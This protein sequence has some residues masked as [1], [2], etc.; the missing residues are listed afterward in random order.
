MVV[1]ECKPI[2]RHKRAGPSIVKPNR[3]PLQV[4]QPFLRN[5]EGVF[6]L[7]L[8][9]WEIVEQPHSFV[10]EGNRTD[11]AQQHTGCNKSTSH[12]RSFMKKESRQMPSHYYLKG[13]LFNIRSHYGAGK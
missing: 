5:V 11:K 6:G 1:R 9:F 13:K 7:D 8:C 12:K 10:R 2:R 4:I 3:G